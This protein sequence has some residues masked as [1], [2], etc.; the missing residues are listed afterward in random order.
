MSDGE[1]DVVLKKK[2]LDTLGS[3]EGK[4]S[5]GNEAV[6]QGIQS[7]NI[8]V[9]DYCKYV[10]FR[11]LRTKLDCFIISKKKFLH[12][13]HLYYCFYHYKIFWC[14]VYHHMSPTQ[15]QPVVYLTLYCGR[16]HAI[17]APIFLSRLMKIYCFS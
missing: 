14:K 3:L 17:V 8:N 5:S 4:V 15:V 9:T 2:K 13:F 1:D 16:P 12:T 10:V 11:I 6:K 7:G